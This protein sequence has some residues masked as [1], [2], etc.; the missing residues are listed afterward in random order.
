MVPKTISRFKASP[1]GSFAPC[2][3]ALFVR[4]S[5]SDF[6]TFCFIMIINVM[7]IAGSSILN[8]S[9]FEFAPFCLTHRT[10]SVECS[11]HFNGYF[12]FFVFFLLQIGSFSWIFFFIRWL[13]RSVCKNFKYHLLRVMMKDEYLERT[14]SFIVCWLDFNGIQRNWS[15]MTGQNSFHSEHLYE[16]SWCIAVWAANTFNKYKK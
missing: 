3:F 7:V 16:M 8:L 2:F 4:F 13:C 15:H 10:L 11:L 9:H 12:V 6:S 1:F 5:L 14:K